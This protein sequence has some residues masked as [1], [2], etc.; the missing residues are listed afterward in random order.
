MRAKILM[1]HLWP[2][3]EKLDWDDPI[4][5]DNKQQ[6]STFFKELPAEM[7]QVK[8]ER[9]LKPSDAVCNPVLIIFCDAS[10]DAYGSCVSV[11][12]QGQGGGFACNLIVSKNR[13]AP[14]KKM[15]IETK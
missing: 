12:W 11:R 7:N 15:S 4:P 9:C 8:F 1:R 3:G 13:L 2:T 10:E 6:W 14:T 5:D